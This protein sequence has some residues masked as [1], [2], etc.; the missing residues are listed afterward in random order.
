MNN[1]NIGEILDTATGLQEKYDL[2]AKEA[3]F[4]LIQINELFK[5]SQA[6]LSEDELELYLKQY[7]LYLGRISLNL[8]EMDK[9]EEEYSKFRVKA[10]IAFNKEVLKEHSIPNN[11]MLK[12]TINQIINMLKEL[13]I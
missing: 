2:L 4:T 6:K 3:E 11:T 1:Y 5:K 13:G 9:I 8:K 12:E 10:N 7:K